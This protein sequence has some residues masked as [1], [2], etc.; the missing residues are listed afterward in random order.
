MTEGS[1][2]YVAIDNRACL[3]A[4]LDVERNGSTHTM[5]SFGVFLCFS[6]TITGGGRDVLRRAYRRKSVGLASTGVHTAKA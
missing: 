5:L 4:D 1:G 2:L 3:I 6:L